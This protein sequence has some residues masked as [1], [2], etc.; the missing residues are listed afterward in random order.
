VIMVRNS[1]ARLASNQKATI[2]AQTG[3]TTIKS[4][5]EVFH[6]NQRITKPAQTLQNSIEPRALPW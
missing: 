4:M 2:R 6:G 1:V 3:S 5:Q